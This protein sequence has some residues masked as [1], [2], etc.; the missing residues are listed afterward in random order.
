MASC[1][2]GRGVVAGRQLRYIVMPID[3]SRLIGKP[4]RVTVLRALMFFTAPWASPA[5]AG[6]MV[7]TG[8]VG[9]LSE[10]EIAATARATGTGQLTEYAGPLVAKHVGS[11][12]PN[13][14]VEQSGEIRFRRT[15][16]LSSRIE[17]VLTLWDE[18]C[19]FEVRAATHE[20]LV[21]CPN[22]GGVPLRLKI[23]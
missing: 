11:C 12:T 20:G 9:Y 8:R 4:M 22:K 18:Q 10:W 5:F 14:S 13:G 2:D 3:R 21:K 16:F 15:G 7:V 1:L 17:G 6:D 23:D 19:A